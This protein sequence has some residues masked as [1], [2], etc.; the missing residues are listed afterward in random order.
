MWSPKV[1]GLVNHCLFGE[2]SLLGLLGLTVFE[3][4][5]HLGVCMRK[6][7]GGSSEALVSG[8]CLGYCRLG[9]SWFLS[10]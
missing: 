9:K 4:A 6:S 10:R 2:S 7:W 5:R 8:D 3:L 1:C